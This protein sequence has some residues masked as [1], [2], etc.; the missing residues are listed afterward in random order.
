MSIFVG[1]LFLGEW[2]T[3]TVTGDRPPPINQFSLTPITNDTAILFGGETPHG[4]SSN[5]YIIKFTKASVV[6]VLVLSIKQLRYF[7]I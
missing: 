6:S 7:L 1:L 3:P 2:I 4:D 5:V